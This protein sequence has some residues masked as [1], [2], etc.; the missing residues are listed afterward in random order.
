MNI[1]SE[2]H[3]LRFNRNYYID[4]KLTE[5]QTDYSIENQMTV[6]HNDVTADHYPYL[7]LFNITYSIL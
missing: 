4:W 5:R 6:L 3:D 2:K 7:H 1:L